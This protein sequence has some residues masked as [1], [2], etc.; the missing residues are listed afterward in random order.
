[1]VCLV[2]ITMTFCSLG[3]LREAR[4]SNQY[5]VSGPSLERTASLMEATEIEHNWETLLMQRMR[6]LSFRIWKVF[7]LGRE[8]ICWSQV[9]TVANIS[10]LACSSWTNLY[11]V[12]SKLEKQHSDKSLC[13]EGTLKVSCFWDSFL[14]WFILCVNT[15]NSHLWSQILTF[16]LCPSA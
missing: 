15:F 11:E 5:R 6:I 12:M 2:D 13:G 16:P 9:P 3:H 1:M 8:G 4:A 14:F 7:I 10:S